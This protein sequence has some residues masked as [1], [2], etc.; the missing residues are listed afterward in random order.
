MNRGR[1]LYDTFKMS[2]EKNREKTALIVDD[3]QRSY[4]YGELDERD[5]SRDEDF[6]AWRDRGYDRGHRR[7]YYYTERRLQGA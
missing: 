7:R 2:A 3:M 1:S 5:R 6:R 4:S